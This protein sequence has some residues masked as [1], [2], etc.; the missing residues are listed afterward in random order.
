MHSLAH[1]LRFAWRMMQR[2]PGVTA[3]AVLALGL[4]IGANTAMF[5]VLNGVLLRPLPFP[6]SDRLLL[7]SNTPLGGPFG[8]VD[9]L[10]EPN[11]LDFVRQDQLFDG[12][13]MFTSSTVSLTGEGEPARLPSAAITSSFLTVLGAQPAI[14]R[15]FTAAEE[16][17]GH[18]TVVLLGD[19]LWRGRFHADP[20]VLGRVIRLD[21]VP[22]TVIGV[23]P[24][25]FPLPERAELYTPLEVRLPQGNS[26]IRP[27]IGRLKP[28]VTPA[29]ALAEL[30]A[31]SRAWQARAA[32]GRRPPVPQV[33]P[34]KELLI[35]DART[36][37]S[38]LAGTVALVLLIACANVANL[39]LMR[40]E[41]RR[42]EMAVRL[43]LGAG[44]MRLIRQML[45][46]SVVVSMA[47]GVVGILLAMWGVPALLAL[48]PEGRIPRTGDI[49]IDGTVLA[50]TIALA[51]ATGLVFGAAPAF[52]SSRRTVRENLSQAARAITGAGGGLRTALACG[53]LALALILLSGAGLLLKSLWRLNAVDP[54]FHPEGVLTMTVN[55]PDAVYHTGADMKA[56]H[57]GVLSRLAAIPGA[58]PAAINWVPLGPGLSMGNFQVE[59]GSFPADYA[60]DKLVVSPGYF[61]AMG[62]RVLSGRDFSPADTTG[63]TGVAILSKSVVET[64][65]PGQ[66][67]LGKRISEMDRPTAKDWL[68]IVGVVDDVRQGGQAEAPDSA[69]YFP[70]QQAPH[71]GWLSHVTYVVGGAAG[72]R[73]LAP[74]MRAAVRAVDQEQPVE[75]MLSLDDLMIRSSAQRT[76]QARLLTAF[77]LLALSLALI[78]IY[79]VL[80]YGVATRTREI[81]IRM[82]LGAEGRDVVSMVLRRTLLVAGCGLAF[83]AVGSLAATRVLQKFLFQ[84]K[85]GDA[86]TL[87]ASACLLGACALAAGWIPARRAAKVDPLVALRYE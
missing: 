5:T 45:T 64:L 40:A 55:L 41:S 65:W 58:K 69:L 61:R 38:I 19:S 52:Q 74:A 42:Q 75:A 23:M 9:G 68:T 34:L 47:G 10:T 62:I 15:N 11:Y 77:A 66:D 8:H 4:G 26:F 59:G 31:F 3:V 2:N 39:L 25:G 7:L 17:A 16:P 27:A 72:S 54:G 60:V 36:S 56:F 43:A 14:G 53:E 32:A 76:F 44:R 82:A 13:A 80:S 85:P 29:A 67:A 22:H 24:A 12:V 57:S 81:G 35:G 30:T 51:L 21:G 28:G 79:G 84:V 83:G 46:E 86:A 71:A 70:Y 73:S 48:A 6:Q 1:D 33:Q 63:T 20:K 78:G 37:L 87:M 49:R 18:D 50:F